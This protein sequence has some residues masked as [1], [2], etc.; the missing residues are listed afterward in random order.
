MKKWLYLWIAVN[1]NGEYYLSRKTWF[2]FPMYLVNK[3]IL[4]CYDPNFKINIVPPWKIQLDN[5]QDE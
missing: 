3:I 2:D 4:W 5:V 1:D